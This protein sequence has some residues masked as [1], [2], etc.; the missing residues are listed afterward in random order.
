[1]PVS[2]LLL[3]TDAEYVDTKVLAGDEVGDRAAAEV[4]NGET[5]Q[6][7]EEKLRAGTRGREAENIR[8]RKQVRT[9]HEQIRVPKRREEI[10]VERAPGEGREASEAEI[11]E[12]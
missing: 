8:V 1:M 7:S 9:D 5:I 10:S 2:E 3:N 4:S 6:R 12:D 11:G